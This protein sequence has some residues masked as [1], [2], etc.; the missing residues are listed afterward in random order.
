[1]QVWAVF[2]PKQA[3]A[4]DVDELRRFHIALRRSVR[5][6]RPVP[7]QF[8]GLRHG[9]SVTFLSAMAAW[10]AITR[11]DVI[12]V[13]CCWF[14]GCGWASCWQGAAVVVVRA[15]GSHRQ[16]GG[17]VG[18]AGRRCWFVKNDRLGVQMWR[19]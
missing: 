14:A 8:D 11:H 4:C 3:K 12:P 1:M 6:T 17:H 7:L 16:T 18:C 2:A 10:Q 15:A 9:D 19:V 13:V 5:G